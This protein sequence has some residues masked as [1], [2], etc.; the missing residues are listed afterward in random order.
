MIEVISDKPQ[1]IQESELDCANKYRGQPMFITGEHGRLSWQKQ[2]RFQHLASLDMRMAAAAH[3][4]AL[5][6]DESNAG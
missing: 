2:K 1:K 5:Q 6:G 3:K 4:A